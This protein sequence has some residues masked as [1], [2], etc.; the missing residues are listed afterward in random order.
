MATAQPTA[1]PVPQAKY[2]ALIDARLG[3]VQRRIRFLDAFS[4]LLVFLAFTLLFVGV[5]V[6]LDR[7]LEM[8][9]AAR[10][11][12]FLSFLAIAG[13]YLTFA[14]VRPWFRQINPYFAAR[15][16]ERLIPEAKNSL[17]NWL[18]LK[19]RDLPAAI[20]QN[21]VGRAVRDADRAPIDQAVRARHVP[22]LAGLVLFLVL[23]AG[24]EAFVLGPGHFLSRLGRILAPFGSAAAASSTRITVLRPEGGNAT[25][26]LDEEHPLKFLVRV[27]G[28]V[29]PKTGPDALKLA[30]R[31]RNDEPWQ[32][33]FLERES[34]REWTTSLAPSQLHV[35]GL[36]YRIT[37]GDGTTE[38]YRIEV[39]SRPLTELVRASYRN[40]PYLRS[41]DRSE[42]NPAV[43]EGARGA[44]VTIEAKANREVATAE[45]IVEMPGQ[46]Q[47][48]A[49]Q[50]DPGR[51]EIMTFQVVLD[52]DGVQHEQRGAWWI[53]F[54]TKENEST[55]NPRKYE[56]IVIRDEVPAVELTVPG[57]DIE[58]PA[59]GILRLRGQAMD[60]HGIKDLKLRLQANGQELRPQAY[61]PE[62]AFRFEDGSYPQSLDYQDFIDLSHLFTPANV[63]FELQPKMQIEYW[64]EATDACDFPAPMKGQT[65]ASKHF[66]ISVTQPE[67]NAGKVAQE[68][69]KAEQEKQQHEEEQDQQ[70]KKEEQ[71]KAEERQKGNEQSGGQKGSGSNAEK[72]GSD[73]RGSGEK[74]SSGQKGSGS[75][76]EKKSSDDRGSGEKQ[77]SGQKGS[78]SNAEKKGS[79]D[80]GSGDKSSGVNEPGKG[81]GKEDDK[82]S[83]KAKQQTGQGG[84]GEKSGGSAQENQTLQRIEK[85]LGKSQPKG[86]SQDRADGKGEGDPGPQQRA[87]SKGNADRQGQPEGNASKGS[88]VHKENAPEPAGS[89]GEGKGDA[90]Q[91]P[92]DGKSGPKAGQGSG[93]P[94]S[95]PGQGREGGKP[96]QV[97]SKSDPKGDGRGEAKEQAAEAK[98]SGSAA[99]DQFNARS[100]VKGGG[101]GTGEQEAKGETRPEGGAHGG[102]KGSGSGSSPQVAAKTDGSQGSGSAPRAES[103]GSGSGS[104]SAEG[105]RA[106]VK[107]DGSQATA[108]PKDPREIAQIKKEIA[109]P[110]EKTREDALSRLDKLSKDNASPT[111]KEAADRLRER[112]DSDTARGKPE[113]QQKGSGSSDQPGESRDKLPT[114]GE[115]AA[116]KADKGSGGEGKGESKGGKGSTPG[117]GDSKEGGGPP[118]VAKGRGKVDPSAPAN[119]HNSDGTTP[120]V[121]NGNAPSSEDD[122]PRQGSA[123]PR[124]Q[125]AGELQLDVMKER[126]KDILRDPS[127]SEEDRKRFRRDLADLNAIVA[128]R[129]REGRMHDDSPDGNPLHISGDV[130]GNSLSDAP[131]SKSDAKQTSRGRAPLHP[132]FGQ[133]AD[134]YLNDLAKIREQQDKKK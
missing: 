69:D 59:N 37:G 89:K 54:T 44:Q 126:L 3:S 55:S 16:V 24:I 95:Q 39:R 123:D 108:D 13:I 34:D 82:G 20:R 2:D 94:E 53:N 114:Q 17:V 22:W 36:W 19:E 73:D 98:G 97:T 127:I 63:P 11:L 113:G 70:L 26:T 133:N 56:I 106:E 121:R 122:P 7:R 111:L 10:A 110:D 81:S 14:L 51:P 52:Q 1:R 129:Q 93:R 75:N 32:D 80:R 92:G 76:A 23:A 64:L 67:S 125:A 83:G 128:R 28:R 71:Q 124:R 120:T 4:S 15:S 85:D 102:G 87:E 66:R 84:S 18:D 112:I 58:L 86:E 42:E 49:G 107:N 65:G 72:K 100:N 77:S 47:K 33:Q 68:R 6:L 101:T 117:S 46:K 116:A 103:K 78:G 118:A 131:G 50:I 9:V 61:R 25:V 27:E 109:S 60:D 45:L 134:N 40:R 79:D 91:Q 41:L 96:E 57:R 115:A 74:Q 8:G 21:V 43:L 62:K 38:E 5:M 30:Y 132:V 35:G 105:T 99:P 48:I 90:A 104:G 29:P 12:A 88:G 31:F 119:G 130:S